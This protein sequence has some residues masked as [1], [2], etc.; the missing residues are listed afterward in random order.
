VLIVEFI[1]AGCAFDKRELEA[2]SV[3]GSIIG[4]GGRGI[5][6]PWYSPAKC[7]GILPPAP[8]F[9]MAISLCMYPPLSLK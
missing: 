9:I 4:T 3:W 5:S 1:D 2:A 7:M 6:W 8:W